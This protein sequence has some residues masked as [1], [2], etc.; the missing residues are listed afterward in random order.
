[1]RGRKPKPTALKLVGG[2]P[3]KRPLPSSEPIPPAGALERPE[4]LDPIA[5]EMWEW[6]SPRLTASKIARPIDSSAVAQY[7][8]TYS[9][10]RKAAE[11]LA[12]NGSVRPVYRA[13][14]KADGSEELRIVDSKEWPQAKQ[15]RNLGVLLAKLAS[16]LG[17]TPASRARVISSDEPGAKGTRDDEALRR[18]FFTAGA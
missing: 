5:A 4:Y 1:M 15:I 7:C 12:K 13:I 11:F 8:V 18:K 2:N 10:W 6:L 9:E 14:R 17:I 3:G 16:E